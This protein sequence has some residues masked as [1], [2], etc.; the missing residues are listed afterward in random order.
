MATRYTEA[1]RT[2]LQALGEDP[3]EFAQ[4]FSDW[5]AGGA[6]SE[7]ESKLFGKDGGYGV[8]PEAMVCATLM[9]VH[10]VPLAEQ[11]KLAQW[12]LQLKRRARKTS[13]RILVYACDSRN[14]YLLVYILDE[15]DGH[16][17]A[18]MR[19]PEH[20]TL[21]R[22]LVRVAEHWGFTGEIIA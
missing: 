15:P 7:Y 13:N 18:E 8:L 16:K 4:T 6:A 1:L 11:Q 19:T 3:D 10:L 2:Q 14:N 17:I 5:K 20:T 12:N 9:H 22:Q 21:M